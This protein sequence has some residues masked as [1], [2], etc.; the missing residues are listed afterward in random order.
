MKTDLI[1]PSLFIPL[2]FARKKSSNH[3]TNK[4]KTEF[5]NGF[6]V[7]FKRVYEEHVEGFSRLKVKNKN[8]EMEWKARLDNKRKKASKDGKV[9]DYNLLSKSQCA[10]VAQNND[11][12]EKQKLTAVRTKTID[13]YRQKKKK[14]RRQSNSNTLSFKSV[15]K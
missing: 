14:L 3:Q 9:G 2:D 12:Q 5:Q 8:L 11:Y 10:R 13:A 6:F 1:R 4:I 15:F 7:T